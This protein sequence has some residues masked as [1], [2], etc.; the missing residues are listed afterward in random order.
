MMI[1]KINKTVNYFDK[2]SEL[3]ALFIREMKSHPQ[4]FNL[5]TKVAVLYN[6]LKILTGMKNISKKTEESLFQ[7]Y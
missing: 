5:D 2:I 6:C 4:L 3:C 7:L 1:C